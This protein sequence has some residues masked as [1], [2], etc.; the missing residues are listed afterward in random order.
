MTKKKD[1]NKM[2]T[3]ELAGAVFPKKVVEKLKEIAHEGD[4]EEKETDK[5]ESS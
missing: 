1:P 4:D 2:T 3:D 5:T